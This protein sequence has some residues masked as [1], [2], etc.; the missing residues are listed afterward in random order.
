M[1][2]LFRQYVTFF[3]VEYRTHNTNNTKLEYFILNKIFD[4]K[5]KESPALF[6]PAMFEFSG[7]E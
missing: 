7:M 6:A 1:R 4:D 3:I 2:W 5:I